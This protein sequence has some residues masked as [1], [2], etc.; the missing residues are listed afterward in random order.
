MGLAQAFLRQLIDEHNAQAEYL[1]VPVKFPSRDLENKW[2][3]MVWLETATY[4][5]ATEVYAAGRL[6]VSNKPARTVRS[7]LRA[8]MTD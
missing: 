7:Q 8:L 6:G 2:V 5:A 3:Q 4:R 1:A